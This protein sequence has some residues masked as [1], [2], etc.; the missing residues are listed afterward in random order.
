MTRIFHRHPCN[1]RKKRITITGSPTLGEYQLNRKPFPLIFIVFLFSAGC[2]PRTQPPT[3]ST[4]SAAAFTETFAA[5]GTPGATCIAANAP[6]EEATVT[7]VTDGD[8]IVVEEGGVSFRVRYIGIDA[9]EMEGGLL[10][11]E[12]R[13]AD[14]ALVEGKTIVMIRDLSE[15]DRYGR[16]LRYVFSGGVFVNRELVRIGLARA[17]TFPP[18]VACAAEF[19]AAEDEA[20][21]DGRGIWG[22]LGSPTYA[23]N[24]GPSCAG[25]CITPPAGCRIK[26]NISAGGEKIYH[27]PGQKYYD[28]TVIDPEKGERWF[29]SE[30][31]AVAAGWRRSKV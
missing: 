27:V 7:G 26:G 25:G 16:L 29:C 2:A 18:D 28:Q 13:A 11:E 22:L 14:R 17:E 5:T 9:P 20:R 24:A 8:S 1:P 19:Q 12:S 10:A 30:A 15:A 21:R 23:T 4:R 6:R 3:P 31:E